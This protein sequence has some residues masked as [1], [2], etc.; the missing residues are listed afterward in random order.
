MEKTIE[1]LEEERRLLLID[2]RNLQI[3]ERK[4]GKTAHLEEMLNLYLDQ[5]NDVNKEIEKRK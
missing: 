4:I 1:E 3:I 5:L 2:L